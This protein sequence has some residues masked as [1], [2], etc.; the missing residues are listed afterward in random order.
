MFS[1]LSGVLCTA[2]VR[3]GRS[4]RNS[5]SQIRMTTTP[6]LKEDKHSI[7]FIVFAIKSGKID[8]KILDSKINPYNKYCKHIPCFWKQIHLH[9]FVSK[10]IDGFYSLKYYRGC[11]TCSEFWEQYQIDIYTVSDIVCFIM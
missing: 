7:F 10:N 4:T 1:I 8:T 11:L 2:W 9:A 6:L 5:P 3:K